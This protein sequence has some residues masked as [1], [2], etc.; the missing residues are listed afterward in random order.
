LA[1]RFGQELGDELGELVWPLLHQQVTGVGKQFE[2]HE[3]G[4]VASQPFSPFRPKVSLAQIN[5][6][7]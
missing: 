3:A 4:D 5:R 1:R 2:A 6:V 7:G